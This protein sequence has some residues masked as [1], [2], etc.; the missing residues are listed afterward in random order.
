MEASIAIAL[1]GITAEELFLGESGTGPGADLAHAT[2]VAAMM[3]GALGLG[4]SL[5][6]YEAVLDG[7]ISRTNLV[8]KVLGD[9][10][11]K[12]RVEAIMQAQ[13]ERVEGVLAENRDIVMALR[14]A[15]VERD[16][17]VGEEILAVI[18]AALAARE[19]APRPD[20]DRPTVV[21]ALPDV[22]PETVEP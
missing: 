5:I 12:A 16:E 4:G 8:G 2:Q 14:D 18:H 19:P 15:L 21:L 22:D 11:S 9:A 17:L 7:A 3:V 13:K 1:G 6:S 10:G 20:L